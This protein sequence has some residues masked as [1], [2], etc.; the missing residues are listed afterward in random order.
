[1][2][3]RAAGLAAIVLLSAA[4]HMPAQTIE[5][6]PGWVIF[7]PSK[8]TE[9]KPDHQYRYGP[10]LIVNDDGSIDAWF[11]SPGG[12]AGPDG[13]AQWDWI[14]YKRSTDGGRTWTPE[15]V[16]LRPTPGSRDRMSVCDPAAIKL[17]DWYYLGVT[18]VEDW[19]GN[20]NE[21]FV[22]RA[23]DPAGP[24]EKWNGTGWGGSPQPII[25]FREPKD[26][27]GVGEPSFVRKGDTLFIYYT[28]M[29]K[30][31]DGKP[32]IRTLVATAPADAPDWPAKVTARGT[33]F[34]RQP[35]EDSAD[36]KFMD[37]F[38]SFVAISTA[39]R[40]TP[41]SYISVRWSRDGLQFSEPTRLTTNIQPNC[42][43]AGISGTPD[44]HLDV[45]QTN[46]ISYAFGDG[47]RPGTSWGFWHTFL[48]PITLTQESPAAQ[49]DSKIEPAK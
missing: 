20:C 10:S 15:Q 29:S 44:G 49:K 12:G 32:S 13:K 4:A 45:G 9:G 21:I 14:R 43:N 46:Y 39:R 34:E 41:E 25:P 38:D 35:G 3:L 16:V 19:K 2:A 24:Y 1:M 40:M 37:A 26:V 7:D 17:G 5:P 6:Q 11:A 33:A 28:M 30:L 22:A 27:W 31:P 8:A 23:K 48:N 18:A 47:S 42:H 36:V